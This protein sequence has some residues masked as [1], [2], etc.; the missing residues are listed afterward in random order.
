MGYVIVE[1]LTVL[2]GYSDVSWITNKEDSSS[3][4][5]RVF[6]YR[7]VPFHGLPRNRHAYRILL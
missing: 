5:G 4:S 6:K 7:E 2:K 3:A 1:N